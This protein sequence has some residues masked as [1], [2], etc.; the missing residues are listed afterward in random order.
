M[1][2]PRPKRGAF[3]RRSPFAL[4]LFVPLALAAVGLAFA[5]RHSPFAAAE[6]PPLADGRAPCS[7]IAQAEQLVVAWGGKKLVG[8]DT[9]Q[10]VAAR[11]LYFAAVFDTPRGDDAALSLRP[12][13]SA[14][15]YFLDSRRGLA[16][17]ALLIP[18]ALATWVVGG[19]RDVAPKGQRL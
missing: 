7:T 10:A 19:G 5:L 1:P 16:C 12:D 11:N 9:L 14:Y 4:A 15:L 2:D 3:A 18:A 6:T 17:D 13:G 8:L